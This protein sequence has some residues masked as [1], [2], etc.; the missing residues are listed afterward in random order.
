[1]AA[2]SPEILVE[3][4]TDP[5]HARKQERIAALTGVRGFAA[6]VVVI[7]H[8]AGYS[9]YPWFGFPT[10][11]PIALFVLSGFL[12]FQPWSKWFL[13]LAP[14]PSIAQFAKRRI[15]RIFPPYLGL[16]AVLWLIFPPSRP[17]SV[18]STVRALTLTNIYVPDGFGHGL[19]HTWSL[20]AELSWY[21]VLPIVG[22]LAGWLVLRRRLSPTAVVLGV[23]LIMVVLTVIWRRHMYETPDLI[24]KLTFPMMFP[25]F[26]VC[27]FGGGLLGHLT[28]MFQRGIGT[29]RL[30]PRLSRH[31]HLVLFLAV[32]AG[33]AGASRLG[34]PWGLDPGTG[35]EDTFRFIMM[36]LM[37]LLLVGGAAVSQPRALF[38]RIFGNRASVAVGRWSYGIY[39]WHLPVIAILFREVGPPIGSAGLLTWI[40]V[41]LLASIPLGAVTYAFIEGPAIALSKRSKR[42]TA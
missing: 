38:T 7:T 35:A 27:F 6:T 23:F 11:G 13:G 19:L 21:A 25:A 36:T 18:E 29:S 32:G 20:G 17:T 37:A 42:S 22:M 41:V 12:L 34:G 1:M 31:G 10:Y 28:V 14:R 3:T 5:E 2:T 9:G 33:V 26:A 16:L 8:C 40:L 4:S 30:M 15:W 24:T 39:L